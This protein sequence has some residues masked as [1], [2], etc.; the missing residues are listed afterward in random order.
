VESYNIHKL[1]LQPIVEN[2]I[3]HGIQK[4]KDRSGTITIQAKK[5][6]EDIVF[7]ISDNGV[8]MD[9]EMVDRVLNNLP[10]GKEGSYGLYNVNERIKLYFGE[11]YGIRI[12]SEKGRGTKIEIKIKAM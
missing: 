2:A 10:N 5:Y 4:N 12:Y 6:N 8:G 7:T 1:T 3:I 9:S 11:E